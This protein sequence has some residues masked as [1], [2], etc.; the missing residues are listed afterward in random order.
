MF[1]S[2]SFTI[3]QEIH[4]LIISLNFTEIE[5]KNANSLESLD[6]GVLVMVT[7]LV[8]AKDF[9][10]RR[11]FVET[12]FLAPQVKGYFVLNDIFLLLEEEQVPR[13]SS[14]MLT[15]DDYDA[16]LDILN[17]IQDPGMLS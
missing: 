14:A 11:N 4:N 2:N 15:H 12:F 3:L 7:G 9:I 13:H 10:C 17:P 16:N 8:Q 1:N 6:G 5:I